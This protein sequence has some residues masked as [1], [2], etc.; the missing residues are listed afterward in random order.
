MRGNA[1]AD[2]ALDVIAGKFTEKAKV[3]R[4]AGV[5]IRKGY[6]TDTENGRWAITDAGNNALITATAGS[7][8]PKSRTRPRSRRSK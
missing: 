2:M 5:L 1:D 6:I 4:S 8:L 3:K 7:D